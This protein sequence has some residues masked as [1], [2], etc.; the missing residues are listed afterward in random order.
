MP[1]IANLISSPAIVDPDGIGPRILFLRV[2][3]PKTVKN[4]MHLDLSSP[5]PDALVAKVERLG[6]AKLQEHRIG[7]FRWVVCADPEGN[8]FCV[9][10]EG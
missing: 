6:G 5:D 10:Q 9:T 7:G 4:R 2:P 8:E 3:E 1:F